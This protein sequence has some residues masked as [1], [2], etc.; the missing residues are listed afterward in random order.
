MKVG[1]KLVCI[2]DFDNIFI[3]GKTYSIIDVDDNLIWVE[4]DNLSHINYWFSIA[5]K[6]SNYYFDGYFVNLRDD[7][8]KKLMKLNSI[9][10]DSSLIVS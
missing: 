10:N 9:S 4:P 7:R 5:N 1:D 2:K 6:E 8:F 3:V